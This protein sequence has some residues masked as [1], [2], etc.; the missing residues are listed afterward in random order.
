MLRQKKTW[1]NEKNT[2]MKK[3]LFSAAV[4]LGFSFF[5]SPVSFAASVS[6]VSPN[7][8]QCYTPGSTVSI[9]WSG[10]DYDHVALAYRMESE[11]SPPMYSSNPSV[12]NIMH[13]ASGSTYGWATPSGISTGVPY[14][15]WIEAHSPSHGYLAVDSSD[16][17]FG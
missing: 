10:T 15:I 12:W 4:T 17:S 3:I 13:P 2:T 8:G 9:T 16:W 11:G 14:K 7:G 6:V 5:I 1:Y